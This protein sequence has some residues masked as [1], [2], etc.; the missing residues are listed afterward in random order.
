MIDDIQIAKA[1][2]RYLAT[3]GDE[4]D[5]QMHAFF[6]TEF[7]DVEIRRRRQKITLCKM[8]VRR[9]GLQ[10]VWADV[11]AYRI[12]LHEVATGDVEDIDDVLDEMDRIAAGKTL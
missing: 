6:E 5:A 8:V 2:D 1:V 4:D 12:G 10:A 9:R 7:A 11:L 3:G